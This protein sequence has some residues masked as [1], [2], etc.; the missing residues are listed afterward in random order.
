MISK[1]LKRYFIN[2]KISTALKADRSVD[3]LAPLKTIGVLINSKEF[4]RSE[5]FLSLIDALEILNKDLKIITF[6]KEEKSVP[7]FQQNY[8]TAKDVTWKGV[9]KKPEIVEFVNRSY[10]VFIGYYS[11]GDQHLDLLSAQINA[12]IKIGLKG[13]DERIFDLLFKIQ[14]QDYAVF[15]SELKKYLTILNQN[16]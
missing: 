12:P 15:E 6:V 4:D 10:D 14:P 5:A 9:I 16:R 7:A 1:R 3:S 13:V 2:R 8:F 11:Q